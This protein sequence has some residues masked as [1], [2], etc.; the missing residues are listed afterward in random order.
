M[1]IA[2]DLD[3]TITDFYS[4]VITFGRL[5]GLE[6]FNNDKIKNKNGFE[7]EEIFDWSD[8]EV[9]EFKKYIRTNLRMKVKP[10]TFVK[11]CINKLHG[12]G[13]EIYILTSRKEEDLINSKENT[14]KWL[15]ENDI[16]FD[17]LIIGNSNKLEEC[18]KHNIDIFI[19]DKIKHCEKV[20]EYGIKTFIV[21]NP[22]N[23]NSS[24]ERVNDFYELY[25]KINNNI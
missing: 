4:Y 25:I 22:Y 23:T 20:N 14:K 9:L 7:I 21:N 1:K 19:D 11:E 24:I 17:H 10:R 13:N 6:N 15:I 3:G 18:I 2:F 5:Y 12:K 8:K 16:Y